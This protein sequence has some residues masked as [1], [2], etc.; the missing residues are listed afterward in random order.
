MPWLTVK[1]AARVNVLR[2]VFSGLCLYLS[3]PPIAVEF[4][5]LAGCCT[6]SGVCT[7]TLTRRNRT[8]AELK[9][10]FGAQVS[11]SVL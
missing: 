9:L 8:G 5:Q 6:L 2:R 4:E 1:S 11:A 7:S 10:F 3:L